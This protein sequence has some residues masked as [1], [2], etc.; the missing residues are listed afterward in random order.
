MRF[1]RFPLALP[2]FH[3]VTLCRARSSEAL[4]YIPGVLDLFAIRRSQTTEVEIRLFLPYLR[5]G[6]CASH[7]VG[8]DRLILTCLRTTGKCARFS[9]ERKLQALIGHSIDIKVLT[10]LKKR[11]N[12]ALYRHE[13][14]SGPKEVPPLHPEPLSKRAAIGKPM[15]RLVG[16]AQH[17]KSK[18]TSRS[19]RTCMSIARRTEKNPKVRRSLISIEKHAGPLPKVR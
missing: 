3:P 14:P 2:I 12:K 13:G 1:L 5:S 17:P 7:A 9:G 15:A 6:D 18:P 10:D 16:S 4:A 19:V 11:R 8:Q